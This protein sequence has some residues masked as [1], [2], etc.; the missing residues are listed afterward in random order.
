MIKDVG[1]FWYK[2]SLTSKL[3]FFNIHVKSFPSPHKKLRHICIRFALFLAKIAF[4]PPP[5][6]LAAL[7]AV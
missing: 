1:K 5:V 4:T 3:H 7:S 6:L 2:L